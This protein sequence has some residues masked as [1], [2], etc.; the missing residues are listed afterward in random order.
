MIIT[1]LAAR[2]IATDWH[3]GQQSA[4]YA[5]SSTGAIAEGAEAELN[6]E[7]I[8]N[9]DTQ[10]HTICTECQRLADLLAYVLYHGI[11]GSQPNWSEL[12]W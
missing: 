2:K 1:D 9:R 8:Y 10:Q 7:I 12:H 3:G 11:R 6:R 4:L 5:L